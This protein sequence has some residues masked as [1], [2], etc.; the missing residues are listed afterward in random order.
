MTSETARL[1]G[2]SI[3]FSRI[4]PRWDEYF[5]Y[6]LAWVGQSGKVWH[7]HI[8]FWNSFQIQFQHGCYEYHHDHSQKN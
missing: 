5:S 1:G 2:I 8:S 6:D 3:D 7:V 4:P